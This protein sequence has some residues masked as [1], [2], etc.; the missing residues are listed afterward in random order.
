M[1]SALDKL[2]E[3]WRR[4]G[5]VVVPQLISAERARHL[6]AICDEVLAEWRACDPQTGLPGEKPDATVMRHL[7]HPAYFAQHPEWLL[8]T[9]EAAA[10][11]DV[12]NLARTIFGE[13][14]MFRCTSLFASPSGAH[15][16]GNWHRDAQFMTQTDDEERADHEGG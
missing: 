5:Y 13:A 6:C 4:E 8:E 1:N 2:S 10:D 7:N 14:P 12:L 16:D 3:R 15:L 11:P 9:L